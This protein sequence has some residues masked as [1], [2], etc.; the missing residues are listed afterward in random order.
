MNSPLEDIRVLDLTAYLAG[1][2]VSLNLAGMGAEVIK[3]ERPKIGDPCRWNPPFAG[4]EGVSY[5]IKTDK[6]I[7]LIYLKRNR[8]KKSIFLDLQC[9]KGK[10]IF[11]LL[12]KKADVLLENFSPGTMED[13]G[14]NYEKI[15]QVNSK[16]IY[17]S[18]AGYG[19]SGPY[20]DRSA[21]D[22]TIQATSGIMAV[23]GLPDGPPM[24]CGV[25]VGDLVPALYGMSGILAAL[26]ARQKTGKGEK[27]DISMQDCCF[28]LVM[29]EALDL[30][31]SLGIPVKPGN[32]VG[33]LAP[34]NVFAA[35]NGYIVIAIANDRQWQLFLEAIG[36]EDL[37]EDS[38]FKTSAGRVQNIDQVEGIVN[39]WLGGLTKEQAIERL[40]EKNVPC[41]PLREIQEVL[42]DPQLHF[43][44]MVQ[45]L[46]HPISGRTGIKA[47]GF[48]IKF[49]ELQVGFSEPAPYPG[50]NN[51]EVYEKL[52]GFSPEEMK[53][54]EKEGI[55]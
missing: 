19:Q 53:K 15:Q 50:E 23:S 20:K 27:I 34:F 2:F 5:K 42:G 43:R 41:D 25:W 1:P 35:K 31:L 54:L 11:E 17:C 30:N 26:W 29:D 8:N 36:R 14:F 16:I 49:S 40:R 7:S 4:P 32:R 52:L 48:P 22:L 6:D 47:A 24:R 33:R 38:R 21:F 3:V 18:I 12:I 55:I 44:G 39:G 10:K 46:I 28:S 45:E 13:L 51:E 37:K 9:E